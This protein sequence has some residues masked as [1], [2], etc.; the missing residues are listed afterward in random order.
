MTPGPKGSATVGW[1]ETVGFTP[2]AV[3]VFEHRGRKGVLYLRWWDEAIGN[4]RVKSLKKTLVPTTLDGRPLRGREYSRAV[5]ELKQWARQAGLAKY[6]EIT[7]Q[8]APEEPAPTEPGAPAAPDPEAAARALT[9][10]EGLAHACDPDTG[11]Y[12]TDTPYRRD[13]E[14]AVRQAAAAWDNG[15]WAGVRRAQ[16]TVFW[17]TRIRDV[18]AR[19]EQKPAELRRAGA[20]LSS[21]LHAVERVHTVAQWLRDQELIPAGAAVLPKSWKDDVKRDFAQIAGGEIPEPHQPRYTLEESRALLRKAAEGDPRLYLLLALGA[22]LR[23]GQVLRARRADLVLDGPDAGD[24]GRFTV[25]GRGK[26]RGVVLELTRGQRAAV[27]EALGLADPA[28]GYLRAHEARFRAE[29][30]NYPLFPG[31]RLT[32][33]TKWMGR[34]PGTSIAPVAPAASTSLMGQRTAAHLFEA[35]EKAAGIPK[36]RGRG[37]Y[38]LRRQ[39]VDK[40]SA[41]EVS[42]N[43]LM[44]LGGWVDERTPTKVYRDRE[45]VLGRIEARD[46]RAKIRGEEP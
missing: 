11:K 32:T 25:R 31:G 41:D 12:L 4:W 21:A 6:L 13:I 14:A 9:I 39:A 3:L 46:A 33:K 35:V 38:G 34:K 23:Q 15:P 24:F 43:A 7:G 44:Q 37:M 2:R 1:Q 17:R 36:Q 19:E 45:L 40:A 28:R 22:E 42:P 29:G 27:D 26:K 16:W 20:G 5:E 10:L 8:K 18:R 30:G